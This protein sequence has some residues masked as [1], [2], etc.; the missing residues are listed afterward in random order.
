MVENWKAKLDNEI[1]M[2]NAEYELE[3]IRVKNRNRAQI[4]HETT[5]LL[6]SIFQSI[7][8]FEEALALRVLQAIETAVTDHGKQEITST[9]LNTMLENLHEWLF[10]ERKDIPLLPPDAQRPK[11]IHK[12]DE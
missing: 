8:H 12:S 5:Y 9:E 3:S 4:Q 11:P 10:T 1:N 6:S 7:P 2:I